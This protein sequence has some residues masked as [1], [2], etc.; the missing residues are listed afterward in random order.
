MTQIKQIDKA[1]EVGRQECLSVTL[2]SRLY[3][4]DKL[5]MS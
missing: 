2:R 3:D 5:L 4:A 1:F